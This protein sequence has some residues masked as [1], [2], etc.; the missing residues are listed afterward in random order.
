MSVLHPAALPAL[1]LCTGLAVLPLA[2]SASSTT[3]T[4]DNLP[5]EQGLASDANPLSTA[6]GGSST[7]SGVTFNS[8]NNDNG[9]GTF[10]L[11]N[12]EV[13][14]NSYMAPFS[15]DDFGQS[16][17]GDYYLAGNTYSGSDAFG[18]VFSGLTLSTHQN[19]QS[20]YVGADD[21][22]F[23]SNDAG[24]LTITAFG[25]SGDLA[26]VTTSLTNPGLSFL[27]TSTQFGNLSGVT[28][29]LFT[30]DSISL[31]QTQGQGYT[32]ADD[33]TF[34][35]SAVPE[36][37]TTVSFGLLLGL[38]GVVIAKKRRQAA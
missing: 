30:T 1:L 22:G 29:Y 35:S 36:A 14:N 20:L 16:H 4:F 15:T 32:L 3:L 10:N 37:S 6:N 26:S 7:I 28:G 21:N 27:D 8:T 19:L 13:I 12:W 24:S 5:T 9:D 25:A 33:L 17:S 31:Y 23:G 11:V 18:N 38:G 34:N 2:A